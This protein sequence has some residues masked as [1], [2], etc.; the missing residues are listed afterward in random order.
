M[1]AMTAEN[2]KDILLDLLNEPVTDEERLEVI[3]K[4]LSALEL[5]AGLWAELGYAYKGCEICERM[6]VLL[7][8]MLDNCGHYKRHEKVGRIKGDAIR[9]AGLFAAMQHQYMYGNN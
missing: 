5:T 6:I 7:N 2:Q 3:P 8:N 4:V 1:L 9:I